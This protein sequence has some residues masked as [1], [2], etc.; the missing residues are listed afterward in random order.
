MIFELER[1]ELIGSLLFLDGVAILKG[2][3]AKEWSDISYV[4]LFE[5]AGRTYE[6]PLAKAHKSALTQKYALHGEN[7]DKCW[8]T[9][10]GYAG[11]DIADIPLGAYRL[12][13]KVITPH[14]TQVIEFHAVDSQVFQ[15]EQYQLA[16][17]NSNQLLL[18][19]YEHVVQ[20]TPFQNQKFAITGDYKDSHGNTITAPMGLANCHVKFYG[21]NNQVIIH[22]KNTNLKNVFLELMMDNAVVEIGE[23]V[24]V[25]GNWR[26]GQDCT[27]MIGKN[28]SSTNPVYMTCAENSKIIIGEDCMFATNNQIRTDDAHPI[29]DVNTGE[30]INITKDVI[31]GDHVWIGYGVTLLGGAVVG[32]GSVLGAYALVNKSHPN[33]CLAVGTPAKTVKHDIFWERSPLLVSSKGA[34]TY[35]KEQMQAKSYCQKTILNG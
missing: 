11:V 29:Y 20:T 9:T 19:S 17:G 28:S 15:S 3:S 32:S 31:L 7:Y 10:K 33:N 14:K 1:F 4:L 6:K 27:L 23:N 21:K 35:T 2:V 24:R 13:L 12:G 5:S 8:F 26:I 16:L 18:K 22:H 30:R 34:I 25:A